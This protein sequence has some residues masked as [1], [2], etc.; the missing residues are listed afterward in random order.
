M[1]RR[2]EVR[3]VPRVL[4]ALTCA[5]AVGLLSAC[6][7]A[8][9]VAPHENVDTPRGAVL[10]VTP[11]EDLTA[12]EVTDRL[13]TA[14]IDPGEVQHGVT[15]Y[16]V[17]YATVDADGE[18]TTASQLVAFPQNDESD[19]TVV[20]WLHGTTVYRGD[21]A[22]VN[23]DSTDRAA[24]LLFASAGRAVSAPDYL[25]LGEGT[26]THPYG[27]PGATVSVS[28]DALRAARELAG[29]YERTF[30]EEVQVSGFSQGGPATMML[31]R[32]LQEGVD[33][34]FELGGLAPI[35]GP[36]DLSRFEGDAADDRIVMASLYLAYFVTAWD[37]L[38]DLY[39]T[40][41]EAF[42]EP[43]AAKVE[44]LFD[45]DHRSQ[46]IAGALPPTSEALF[47]SEFLDQVRHP[48]GTLR[49]KLRA[50]DTTCDWQPE[51]PVHLFHAAGDKDVAFEHAR[52]CGR[53]LAAHGAEQRLTDIGDTDHNGTVRAA[54]PQVVR[55]FA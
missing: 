39:D 28:L 5:V 13:R 2:P 50:L 55:A 49:Q 41:R 27:H 15:A 53:R 54:L 43:Y 26:G 7:T 1:F 30:D 10:E 36:F 21:A 33:P 14:D 44:G 31:G 47:T 4:T 11:V 20:S 18:P 19:L 52:Y 16:R 34:S 45:G 22:S 17:V 46:E 42:R 40:P 3:T 6:A 8:P 25:G 29:R 24:A 37:R 35:A 51:V 32:A 23:A 9:A 48:S 38:Y 12:A